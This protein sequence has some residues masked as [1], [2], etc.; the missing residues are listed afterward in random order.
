MKK[1]LIVLAAMAFL[2]AGCEMLDT[3]TV[4]TR[5]VAKMTCSCVFVS[6][7]DFEACLA[8]LPEAVGSIEISY[9]GERRHIKAKALWISAT[10]S[11]EEG[12]G[13]KIAG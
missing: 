1:T 9:D 3:A 6:G 4:G 11:H 8:D 2:I 13:C 12:K 7:R 10:A 5:Y